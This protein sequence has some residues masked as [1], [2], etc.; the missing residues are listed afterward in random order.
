MKIN[1]SRKK[2]IIG[3]NQFKFAKKV[4]LKIKISVETKISC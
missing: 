1:N 4:L 3:P 2:T